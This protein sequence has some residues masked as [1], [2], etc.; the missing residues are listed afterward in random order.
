MSESSYT[1][2]TQGLLPTEQILVMLF[3]LAIPLALFIITVV[4]MS[5]YNKYQKEAVAKMHLLEDSV[6]PLTN[7][8]YENVAKL[9]EIFAEEQYGSRFR[10]AWELVKNDSRNRYAGRWLPPLRDYFNPLS[11]ERPSDLNLRSNKP[12]MLV[13]S[14]GALSALILYVY[15]QTESGPYFPSLALVPLLSGLIGGLFLCNASQEMHTRSTVYYN[16]LYHA[17]AGVAPVYDTNTGVSLLID[18]ILAHESKLD[19]SIMKFTESSAKMADSDFSEAIARSVK[20]IMQEE[21][22]PPIVQASNVLAD[23]AKELENRQANGMRELAQAFS[24]HLADSIASHLEP[25]NQE[26]TSINRL[27][28]RTK[29]FIESSIEVLNTNREQNIVLNEEI[30]E[31]LRLMTLAKND[32]ANEMTALSDNIKVISETSDKMARAYTGEEDALSEKIKELSFTVRDTLQ[33]YS[34][35]VKSSSDAIQLATELKLAQEKQHEEYSVQLSNVIANLE[36]LEAGIQ[37]ATTNFTQESSTYI[38][39]TL[40]SFDEGLAEVVERLL[41]TTTA[42]R[43]AV[44]ALPSALRQNISRNS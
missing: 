9:D 25:I 8:S 21:V 43:D 16:N 5:R 39:E 11:L 19:Q 22:T 32:L 18:E 1:L 24:A 40:Q 6:A 3:A 7:L 20:S 10:H 42:L 31:S 44:D 13:L 30:S 15:L 28:G 41:F 26:L 35:A 17:I 29:D 36:V 4:Y 12:G 23:L 2:L 38:N 27:M 33:V 14:I 37:K 34:K